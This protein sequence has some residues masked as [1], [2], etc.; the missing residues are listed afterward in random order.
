MRIAITLF[1]LSAFLSGKAQTEPD[2]TNPSRFHGALGFTEATLNFKQNGAGAF[3]I[4]MRYD[5]LRGHNSA[6]GLGTH[7][8]FGT[9]DEYGVSFP[10]IL[11]LLALIGW[12]GANPDFSNLNTPGSGSGNGYSINLFA[13]MPLLLQY[14]WGLG[15][16][17][18]SEHGFGW[19]VGGGMTYTITGLTVSST[20]HGKQVDFLGW[21]GSI[22][23]RFNRDH[24]LS[25]STT[26]P[27][28]NT[29]GSVQHPLF[30]AL[31]FAGSFH[32]DR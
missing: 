26:V 14:N 27:L 25:F 5:L 28:Q 21:M 22:G 19:S 29:V 13:D 31:T 11:I 9:E 20:G 30:F 2:Q 1:L 15:T 6:L 4:P 12:S 16:N 24:E 3:A 10:G 23:V 7:L 8:K 32:K 18:R 17:N